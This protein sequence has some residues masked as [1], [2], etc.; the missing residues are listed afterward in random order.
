M[1]LEAT[2]ICVDN[3]ETS[4]NGDYLPN[5]YSAQRECVSIIYN[6]KATN[7]ESAV[8]LLSMA[9]KSPSVLTTPQTNLGPLLAGLADTKIQGTIR[10]HTS[11]SVA[12]LALK[13]RANKSQRQRVIVLLCS[14]L[15]SSTD[16]NDAEKELIRLAKKCKKNNVSVDFVAFGDA[17]SSETKSILEKFVEE[18]GVR[19]S[20]E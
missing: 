7:P 14:D 6:T 3:S 18:V 1:P 4:R 9:A 11:I 12:M 10:L 17:T 16:S 20:N 13:H 8:G 19:G 5:R 2:M 15:A